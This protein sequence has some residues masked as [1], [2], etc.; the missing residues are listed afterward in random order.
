MH[1]GG[2]ALL[3][4]D[5]STDI[6][7][8]AAAVHGTR[9]LR[10]SGFCGM[11]TQV[12]TQSCAAMLRLRLTACLLAIKEDDL[13][14]E[15]FDTLSFRVRVRRRARWR[16][17]LAALTPHLLAGRR[18][19]VYRHAADRQLDIVAGA[20]LRCFVA[21]GGAADAGV[22]RGK[23]AAHDLW[24]AFLFAPADEWTEVH[25][26]LSRFL[27][28]WRGKARGVHAASLRCSASAALSAPLESQPQL[29]RCTRCSTARTR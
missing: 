22:R 21:A 27:K 15:P 14:L 7:D 17:Q 4:G 10:R 6:S 25:V 5:L 1:A 2:S 16:T 26:P 19:Q 11:R 18:T 20:W 28:T 9:A 23:G 8:A 24:Q 12:R 13:D 3:H 29:L